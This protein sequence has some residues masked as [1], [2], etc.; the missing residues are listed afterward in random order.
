MAQQ[1]KFGLGGLVLRYLD[2]T[3]THTHTVGPLWSSD[4]LVAEA[5]TYSTQTQ[6]TNMHNLSGIRTHG[7]G[8]RAAEEEDYA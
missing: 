4:Q 8:N 1:P 5:A 6:N 3:Y 7:P 2:H